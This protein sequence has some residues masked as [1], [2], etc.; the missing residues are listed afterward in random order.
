MTQKKELILV[1]YNTFYLDAAFNLIF[2]FFPSSTQHGLTY[3]VRTRGTRHMPTV[4]REEQ[5]AL[6]HY[7][8]RTFLYYTISCSETIRELSPNSITKREL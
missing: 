3:H 4:P 8:A 5:A 2:F 6:L 1:K 7:V